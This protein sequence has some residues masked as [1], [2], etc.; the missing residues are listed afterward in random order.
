MTFHWILA[1]FF[2]GGKATLRLLSAEAS[3]A[4]VIVQHVPGGTLGWFWGEGGGAGG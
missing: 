3:E 2:S 4:A 1:L